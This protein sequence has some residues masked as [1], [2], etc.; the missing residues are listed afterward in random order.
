MEGQIRQVI[1]QKY[2]TRSLAAFDTAFTKARK[3]L[4]GGDGI[5]VEEFLGKPV[6]HWVSR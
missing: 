5:A 6:E 1:R 2:W 4:V 3:L